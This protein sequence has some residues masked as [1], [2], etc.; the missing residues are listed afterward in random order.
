MQ[1]GAPIEK[2]QQLAGHS[3][4][5]TTQLYYKPSAQDAEDAARHIQIR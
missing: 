3:D 1:N 2:V 5:R 4:I